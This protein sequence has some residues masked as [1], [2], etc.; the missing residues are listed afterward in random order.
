MQ[1]IDSLAC[2]TIVRNSTDPPVA[3]FPGQ[4]WFTKD[5]HK[6]YFANASLTWVEVLLPTGGVATPAGRKAFITASTSSD[7]FATTAVAENGPFLHA[8]LSVISGRVY[9]IYTSCV[10]G[11]DYLDDINAAR[12]RLRVSSGGSTVT[13]SG[14]KIAEVHAN[15]IAASITINRASKTFFGK[16]TASFTGTA[17]FGLFLA[18]ISGQLYESYFVPSNTGDINLQYL[19][20]EEVSV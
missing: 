4:E 8:E 1:I 3:A 11:S 7:S 12:L 13:T 16:W 5:T 17:S 10:L 15:T 9:R 14:T 19:A 2:K 20:V 6:F 18:K